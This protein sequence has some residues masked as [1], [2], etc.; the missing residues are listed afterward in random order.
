[1]GT[2][3]LSSPVL[4]PKRRLGGVVWSHKCIPAVPSIARVDLNPKED[5]DQTDGMEG[6]LHTALLH[7]YKLYRSLTTEPGASFCLHITQ[8][9]PTSRPT[10]MLAAH[11]MYS[12]EPGSARAMLLYSFSICH[13]I[14]FHEK[15][16]SISMLF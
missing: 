7:V 1:M 9:T 11:F 3:S 2:N 8:G 16:T 14:N 5:T 6:D 13:L 10:A 12:A 15:D 4:S